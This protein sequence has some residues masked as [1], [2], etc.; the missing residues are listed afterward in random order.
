MIRSVLARIQRNFRTRT[1]DDPK[2]SIIVFQMGRVGSKTVHTSLVRAYKNLGQTVPV[3]H[4]HI[5]C[6]F[7]E[8]EAILRAERLNPGPSLAAVA[9]GRKLKRIIDE[10]PEMHWK[11]ISLVR[12]PIARNISTFFANLDEFFPGWNEQD[13]DNP[14]LVEK[15]RDIFLETQTIHSEPTRWFD[16]QMF[17]VFGVDVFSESFPVN[18]G[19]KIYRPEPRTSVLVMRLEDLTHNGVAAMREFLDLERF[20]LSNTNIGENSLYANLYRLFRQIPLPEEYIREI[21]SSKFARTFYSPDEINNF[22]E[23]WLHSR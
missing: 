10:S 2:L 7:D 13:Q 22:K 4:S 23:F 12:E 21:Y 18:I 20:K 11:I 5:L 15:A 9:D 14:K 19:Y 17:P 6:R 1:A 8:S 16:E 3:Y